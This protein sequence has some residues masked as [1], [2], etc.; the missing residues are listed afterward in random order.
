MNG[1]FSLYACP[2]LGGFGDMLR[3]GNGLIR[4]ACGEGAKWQEV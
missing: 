4:A 2:V 1:Y 3:Q